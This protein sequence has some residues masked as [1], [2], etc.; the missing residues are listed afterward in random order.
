M[1][2]ADTVP[3]IGF[4]S[5]LFETAKQRKARLEKQEAYEGNRR[6]IDRM[7][8]QELVDLGYSRHDL[9]ELVYRHHFR[10]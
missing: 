6:E 5:R 3:Q 2:Y 1:A 10:G 7:S 4:F 9:Q 8:E